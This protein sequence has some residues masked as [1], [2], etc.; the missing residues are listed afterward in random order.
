AGVSVHQA[1]IT[2]RLFTPVADLIALVNLIL[3]FQRERF[4]IV[5]THTPKASF[6]GQIAAFL[7]RVPVRV[8]T[9]HGLYFQRGSSWQKKMIFIPIEYIKARIVHRAFSVNTEDVEY[10]IE[11][12]IY[13][14]EKIVYMGGGVDLR[15]LDPA[16]FS[17]GFV[18]RKRQSL[19]I[20]PGAKVVGIVARLVKEKGFLPLFEAFAE[21]KKQVPE[22]ILLVVG[23]EEPEKEDALDPK[24]VSRYGIEESVIFLGERTDVEELYPVMDVFV[25]PSFREGLGLSILEASAMKVPVVASD[26]RGCR[27]GVEDGVT[28]FLVPSNNPERLA[29]AL[30]RVLKNPQEA[31]K[32]GEAGRRR[33]EREFNEEV[34]FA[35]M[36]KQYRGLIQER[37]KK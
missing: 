29:E 14:S 35:K 28:G 16:K 24:E 21:V 25:L 31:K 27:E 12:G 15:K 18:E 23:P 13:P 1:T 26:I 4:D 7:T 30:V 6:L 17:R 2:R 8:T 37:I 11:K 10:L 9:I 22:A 36:V 32:M 20:K 19:K 5:H 3:F 34:V 33:V